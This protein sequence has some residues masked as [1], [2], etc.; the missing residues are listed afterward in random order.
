MRMIKIMIVAIISRPIVN[1]D[2]YRSCYWSS[3]ILNFFGPLFFVGRLF[4]YI[5]TNNDQII[6]LILASE[7]SVF[8]KKMSALVTNSAFGTNLPTIRLTEINQ[9]LESLVQT[10]L[11]LLNCR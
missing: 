9:T 8:Q 2:N 5:Q 10:S 11:R 1:P 6:K 7:T 4:D 3:V